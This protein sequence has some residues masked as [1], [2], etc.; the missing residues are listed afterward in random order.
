VHGRT[1]LPQELI[2]TLVQFN[3][4]ILKLCSDL[5]GRIHKSHVDRP[6]I[7]KSAATGTWGIWARELSCLELRGLF[8]QVMNL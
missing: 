8:L 7:E 4:W 3:G 1:H 2:H 5:A 6:L